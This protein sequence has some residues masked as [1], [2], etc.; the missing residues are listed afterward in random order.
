M[1]RAE[2]VQALVQ[3]VRELDALDVEG[4]GAYFL[5]VPWAQYVAIVDRSMVIQGSGRGVVVVVVVV[6]VVARDCRTIERVSTIFLHHLLAP[7]STVV[8]VAPRIC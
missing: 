7:R 1:G 3:L 6:V 5:A 2:T 4:G 8:T